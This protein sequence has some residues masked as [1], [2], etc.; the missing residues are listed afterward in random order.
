VLSRLISENNLSGAASVG[1]LMPLAI[2]ELGGRADNKTVSA[3]ARE[4][5][6]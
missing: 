3:I 1:K 2:K 5:L 6:A 4:L